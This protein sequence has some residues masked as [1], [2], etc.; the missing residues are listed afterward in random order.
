MDELPKGSTWRQA[1]DFLRRKGFDTDANAPAHYVA[2][3]RYNNYCFFSGD[4][5]TARF[6]LDDN[7]RVSR[8]EVRQD[9]EGL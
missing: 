4:M 6:L 2:G 8:V 7:Y 3:T 1:D 5:I 9:S